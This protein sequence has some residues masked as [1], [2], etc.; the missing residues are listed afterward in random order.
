MF[1]PNVGINASTA[2]RGS[3]WRGD[4]GHTGAGMA[5]VS[6][7]DHSPLKL[8]LGSGFRLASGLVKIAFGGLL[9]AQQPCRAP[10]P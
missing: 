1:F 2:K 10:Q 7:S 5:R 3:S 4:G 6:T 9:I 8:A